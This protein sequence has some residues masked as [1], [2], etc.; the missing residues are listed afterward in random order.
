MYWLSFDVS[1]VSG[2]R[3]WSSGKGQIRQSINDLFRAALNIE[4][5]FF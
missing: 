5:M 4:N 1:T 3:E 2:T